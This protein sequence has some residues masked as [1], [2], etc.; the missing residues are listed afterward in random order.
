MRSQLRRFFEVNRYYIVLAALKVL[1]EEGTVE[2]AEV[3]RA[4]RKY[5]VDPEKT[6]PA[7]S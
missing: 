5:R 7:L 3:A 2:L 1:A 4:I 6:N